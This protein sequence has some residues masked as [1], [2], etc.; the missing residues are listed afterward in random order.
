M[1]ALSPTDNILLPYG[2]GPQLY[3]GFEAET[4]PGVPNGTSPLTYIPVEAD[5][6]SFTYDPGRSALQLA[7][8]DFYPDFVNVDLQ[9]K[10]T[11]SFEFPVFPTVGVSLLNLCGLNN[12]PASGSGLTLGTILVTNGGI[13]S[14]PVSAGGTLYVVPP[15]I[16]INGTG[17]GAKVHA[18]MTTP[19]SGIV[20]SVAIDSPGTGYT[21][22]PTATITAEGSLGGIQIPQY[23]T[24]YVGRAAAE[25]VYPGCRCKM[26]TFTATNNKPLMCKLEFEGIAQPITTG[27]TG[28]P[29]IAQPDVSGGNVEYES[30][31]G[32]T[33][34]DPLFNN[35]VWETGS[36]V[37][38]VQEV[39]YIWSDLQPVQLL[40]VN[41]VIRNQM[42]SI[43]ISIAFDLASFYGNHQSNLPSELI[44]VGASVSGKFTRLFT[45]VYEY[46]IFKEFCS[47]VGPIDFIWESV[48]NAASSR[49]ELLLPAAFY[50]T[51]SFKNPMKGAIT[52]DYTIGTIKSSNANPT[53]T[54]SLTPVDTGGSP[55][56]FN[57]Y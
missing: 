18:V 22:T 56:L 28:V 10:L 4:V 43:E 52:E 54:D 8:G 55:L 7:T 9:A 46:S 41:S 2:A 36:P 15:K 23:V 48:C 24:F 5:Q 21:G 12:G 57:V 53:M 20:A 26:I 13:S 11:G 19:T 16:V 37:P 27:I 14:V 44:P 31:F 29:A 33:G 3:I 50:K 30:G 49:L 38:Y 42:E 1:T 17:T 47:L 35:P 39:P 25:E 32:T 6:V 40:N 45:D 51:Q 34:Y